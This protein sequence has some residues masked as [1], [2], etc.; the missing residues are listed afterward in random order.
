LRQFT[1]IKSVLLTLHT[2]L[3]VAQSTRKKRNNIIYTDQFSCHLLSVDSVV[4]LRAFSRVIVTY[5]NSFHSVCITL[6]S[7]FHIWNETDVSERNPTDRSAVHPFSKMELFRYVH[8]L[9]IKSSLGACPCYAHNFNM[10]V[11]SS[12]YGLLWKYWLK[13]YHNSGR[14][15][16]NKIV[17]RNE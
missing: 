3:I 5:L 15:G 2:R 17:L 9:S 13:Y 6:P 7:V 11:I 12:L 8:F 1:K 4:F 16:R 14:N 10:R